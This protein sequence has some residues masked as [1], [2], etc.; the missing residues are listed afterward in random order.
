M[1]T[2]TI[3]PKRGTTAQ[4]QASRRV[5]EENEWGV[6]VTENGHHILRIG[7]GEHLFHEL[8]AVFDAENY[9]EL[10]AQV[11]TATEAAH[12]AT[13]TATEA[14]TR[15]TEAAESITSRI[16]QTTGDSETAMMSQ[17]AVS[18]ELEKNRVNSRLLYASIQAVD[19][20]GAIYGGY[21]YDGTFWESNYYKTIDID[22]TNIEKVYLEG[23][24]QNNLCLYH[25]LDGDGAIL[26]SALK[27]TDTLHEETVLLPVPYNATTLRY[28]FYAEH[29]HI[30]YTTDDDTITV[31]ELRQQVLHSNHFMGFKAI[32]LSRAT[33]GG[34]LYSGVFNETNHYKTIDIDVSEYRQLYV[35][36]CTQNMYCLYHFINDA[37]IILSSNTHSILL[38]EHKLYVV[39]PDG[40]KTFRFTF[41]VGYNHL[42]IGHQKDSEI[43][44]LDKKINEL[45]EMNGIEKIDLGGAVEG[46]YTYNGAWW[47][48]TYYQT[49]DVPIGKAI[50]MVVRGRTYN[51]YCL[52]HFLDANGVSLSHNQET[53]A[54]KQYDLTLTVPY[55]ATTF[56]FTFYKGT[57]EL[58]KITRDMSPEHDDS[59]LHELVRV[60]NAIATDWHLNFIDLHHNVGMGD[61][62]IIPG[63][64]KLWD[65]GN[66]KDLTQKAILM[67]DTVHP[68]T[69]Q[70]IVQMFGRAIANQLALVSPSYRTND[71]A[72]TDFWNGKHILWLGT[73]IPAGTDSSIGKSYPMVVGAQLGATVTNNA[74]G[75]SCV[76]I[77]SSTGQYDT[78]SIGHFYRSLSRTVAEVEELVANWDTIKTLLSGAPESLSESDIKMMKDHS[79]ENLLLP[80]LDGTK[81]M[82]DL[83]VLDH[84]Y[85]DRRPAG[86]NGEVDLSVEPTAQNIQLG[87]LAEDTYMVANNYANLKTA[88]GDDLTG[89]KNLSEFSATLNRN[90]F[91]G[92]MNFIITLIYRY[93]PYAR[94]AIVGNYL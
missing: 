79:F 83:F 9:E 50:K 3:K 11:E 40:A 30:A 41:M 75:T 53:T 46:G 66:T 73:S 29:P 84:G 1:A 26:E 64:A 59:Q 60:Q 37:G 8:S 85:N 51:N 23:S 68:T 94:I 93:N 16:A 14:A 24:I 61:N 56:R 36:G 89:I 58:F 78:F 76:R 70:G 18:G 27:S 65:S 63:T 57:G 21:T 88:M 74:R 82:P 7:D 52:Y 77:N 45:S 17:K 32:D 15:A 87:I 33:Y 71:G 28:T 72:T 19:L 43:Y 90:C 31:E 55:G 35:A 62:H 10:M 34:Y 91:I 5:L 20:S 38:T 48:T 39:V 86:V 47:D 2:S 92:A 12:T 67:K 54:D 4:W 25:F 42:V 22:V 6:E 44:R 49:I 80:W 69:G 81:P 13:Q